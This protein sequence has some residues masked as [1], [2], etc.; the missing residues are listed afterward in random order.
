MTLRII[1]QSDDSDHG[2]LECT[3]STSIHQRHL[4]LLLTETNKVLSPVTPD[5]RVMSSEKGKFDIILE[6]VSA[7]PSSFKVDDS[8]V[9]LCAFLWYTNLKSSTKLHKIQ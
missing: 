6:R 8:W 9:K 2:L 4:H 3:G 5:S 7:F 1:N